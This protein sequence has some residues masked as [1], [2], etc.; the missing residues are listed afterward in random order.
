[1]RADKYYDEVADK[2]KAVREGI[3]D[4]LDKDIREC[5]SSQHPMSYCLDQAVAYQILRNQQKDKDE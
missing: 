3:R 2:A 5:V 4:L 1:M